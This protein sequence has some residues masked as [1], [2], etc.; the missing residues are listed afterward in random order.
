M[1]GIFSYQNQK[2]NICFTLTLY[3]LVEWCAKYAYLKTMKSCKCTL[4]QF[5]QNYKSLRK[6]LYLIFITFLMRDKCIPLIWTTLSV[7][8][9]FIYIFTSHILQKAGIYF[10]FFS[11]YSNWHCYKEYYFKSFYLNS[12]RGLSDMHV[13][14]SYYL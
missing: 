10:L 12:A 2:Q 1:N 11:I 4:Y 14:K 13:S 5:C 8:C 9:C 7:F 6:H 3:Y